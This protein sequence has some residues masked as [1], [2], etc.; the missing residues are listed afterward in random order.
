M[1]MPMYGDI[2]IHTFEYTSFY[3]RSFLF[4]IYL[5][6][7]CRKIFGA[8]NLYFSSFSWRIVEMPPNALI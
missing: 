4:N 5:L 7:R 3:M 1:P 8:S 6:T 2:E